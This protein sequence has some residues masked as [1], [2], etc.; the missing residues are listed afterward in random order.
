MSPSAGH[1]LPYFLCFE[2]HGRVVRVAEA[3]LFAMCRDAPERPMLVFLSEC[4]A[5]TVA[6]VFLR[7]GVPFVITVVDDYVSDEVGK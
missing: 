7:V 1:G 6:P 2:E 3:E 4:F 5:K